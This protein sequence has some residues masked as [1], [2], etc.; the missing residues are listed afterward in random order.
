MKGTTSVVAD[1]RGLQKQIQLVL[2]DFVTKNFLKSQSYANYSV[3][4]AWKQVVI[5]SVTKG[6]DNIPYGSPFPFPFRNIFF[7]FFF[8]LVDCVCR[9]HDFKVSII[10]ELLQALLPKVTCDNFP[11]MV[12]A[13]T[14]VI[15]SLLTILR[16]RKNAP[17]ED[18]RT[19]EEGEDGEAASADLR[20]PVDQLL[21][22]L[23]TVV[24]VTL[25]GTAPNIRK[26]LYCI[27][28]NY[29]HYTAPAQPS[30]L[31]GPI[32][33]VTSNFQLDANQIALDN[34]NLSIVNRDGNKVFL[35]SPLSSFL[36]LG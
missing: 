22:I 5:V 23:R 35:L 19:S 1:F 21:S 14:A 12:E 3:F 28:L 30:I 32:D 17:E 18:L 15:L 25:G 13:A 29:L 9:S 7:Q 11:Q 2:E 33:E 27:L 26:N 10:T 4:E 6:F 20:L 34:G 16:S 31:A 8:F 36:L 24:N